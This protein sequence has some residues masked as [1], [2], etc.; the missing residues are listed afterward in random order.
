MKTE[1]KNNQLV[2]SIP[3]EKRPSSSGKTTIVAS[4]NGNVPTTV[5][6]DGKPVVLGLNA[7]IK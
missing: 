5:Q 4:T 2:I 7:W 1:I 3:I 6:V